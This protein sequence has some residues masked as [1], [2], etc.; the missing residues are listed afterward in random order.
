[1]KE[2][3]FPKFYYDSNLAFLMINNMLDLEFVFK[4]YEGEMTKDQILDNS[5]CH[6]DNR[7]KS[8]GLYAEF[9][10]DTTLREFLENNN[11]II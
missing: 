2:N 3:K 6:Y 11:L 5:K 9:S 8:F 4:Q 10:G 7:L 1:M